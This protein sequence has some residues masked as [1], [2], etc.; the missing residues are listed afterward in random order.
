L[1]DLALDRRPAVRSRRLSRTAGALYLP[2]FALGAFSLI[3]V[4]DTVFVRDDAA[5][6]AARIAEHSGLL[7]VGSL[8]ELYLAL[9]DVVLAALLYLLFRPGSQPL[10]LVAGLFRFTWAVL[11]AVALVTNLAALRLADNPDAALLLLSLHDDV[12]AVGFVAFGAHLAVL[13]YLGW[14][15]RML[16]RIIGVL[17]MVAGAGYVLNSLLVLGWE[18][19]T[20]FALLLP[21]FP[22]ELSLCLWLL[23]KSPRNE[24]LP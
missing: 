17:L 4:R 21:A 18:T 7:R 3:Y 11:A 1:V 23:I 24:E 22:A 14:R 10:A 2:V 16:P 8:V 9:T 19:P 13:G 15:S 6:T 5:A 20:Q 12:A